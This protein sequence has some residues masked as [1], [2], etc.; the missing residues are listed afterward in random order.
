MP[1]NQAQHPPALSSDQQVRCESRITARLHRAASQRLSQSPMMVP[2]TKKSGPHSILARLQFLQESGPPSIL[3]QL[4]LPKSC[5][6]LTYSNID[7]V[8]ATFTTLVEKQCGLPL[9]Q[10]QELEV[11]LGAVRRIEEWAPKHLGRLELVFELS[12][13]LQRWLAESRD[14]EGRVR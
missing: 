12:S 14:P 11:K 6:C 13:I 1:L 8:I 3:A 9:A 7:N 2:V 4:Q 5:M 10:I